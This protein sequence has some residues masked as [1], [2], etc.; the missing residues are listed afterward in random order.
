MGKLTDPDQ[1]TDSAADDNST[2]V[3]I[4]AS[5]RRI[6]L[7]VTGN[8]D[9]VGLQNENGVTLK[10]LYSFLKEQWKDDPNSKNLAA[11]PFPLVPITDESFEF[12][13]GWDFENDTARYLIR[14]AG[15]AVKNTSNVTTQMW[16]G[17]IGLGSILDGDD[18]LYFQQS[19]GGAATNVQL[20]GQ[21][22][23]AV[24]V[25][26][27]DDGDGNTAE[28]SDFDRR[29]YF[30]LFTREYQQTYN[31]STL[32]DIGVV[33]MSA[34]AYRFPLSSGS[35]AIK[36]T[37]ADAAVDADAPYT[38]M[39]ITYYATPQS[40]TIGG[41][42]YNFGIVV[43]ANGGRATEVYEFVQR[44]LRKDSDIDAGAGSVIGKTADQLMYFVGDTLVVG[45]FSAAGAQPDNPHG[46]GSGVYIENLSSLD[47]N[48]VEFYDNTNTKR[49][50]PY[51]AALR[52][53]FGDNLKNDPSAKYWVYFTTLPGAGNDF[54]E[55]G[56]VIVDDASA[57]AMEG[58]VGG[59]DYIDKTF[60]YAAN[61]QGGIGLATGQYV[62][63]AGTIGRSSANVV[64]L[65]AALERQYSNPV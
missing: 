6:K 55:S 48:T 18:Q 27:D 35:D 39:A 9:L 3:F 46:G 2:E 32:T 5:T 57:L 29:G 51:V 25:Y 7:V 56:A 24:Q 42:G 1:L 40:K 31:T 41:T 28:G 53:N 13:E 23:Q 38:G 44:Q 26:R 54:G 20:T 36:V 45:R 49:T 16:A 60:D 10:T 21:V 34:Q 11:F 22:N 30:K 4:N 17:I 65:V 52:I 8:L 64:S 14:D 59:V 50:N 47:A 12:V 63:A 15:W 58:N 43:N 61:V 62:R 33:Q 19:S 37:H